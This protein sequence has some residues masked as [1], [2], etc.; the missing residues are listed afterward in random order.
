MTAVEIAKAEKTQLRTRPVFVQG[1]MQAA[2]RE[3]TG[4][5]DAVVN[6]VT[7]R[8]P[9]GCVIGLTSGGSHGTSGSLMSDV[10]FVGRDGKT[11]RATKGMS[12]T[13]PSSV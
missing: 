4:E 9:A 2:L 13:I 8:L 3:L 11:Y 1:V 7:L 12:L 5:C 6:G 10:E